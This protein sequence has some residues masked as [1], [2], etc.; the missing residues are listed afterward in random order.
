MREEE[1]VSILTER[2]WGV[3]P[4]GQYLT[5]MEEEFLEIWERVKSYT[6]ISVERGYSLFKGVRYIIENGIPGDFV[7]CGVWKGG[8]C[9][10]MAL[11]VELMNAEKRNIFLYDT[12]AGMTE[13]SDEDVIAWTGK[14]VYERWKNNDFGSWSVSM[15]DVR[16]FIGSEV[17]DMS[18]FVFVEGDV[19]KT[20]DEKVP[21]EISLLRL[22]TDWYSSTA[23]ELEVMYP[24]LSTGGLLIIDDYGHFKGA[25]KAVD[26]YFK[27]RRMHFSRI[28]YTGR[29]GIKQQV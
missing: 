3:I 7:E 8:A 16:S 4:P 21:E 12:F 15:E 13:P 11:T 26:D 5:D 19:L 1:A 28:D 24:L 6:M 17:S 20:L 22:D 14:S 10:L 23:K 9:M 18:P 25:R 27:N 29:E 2:G